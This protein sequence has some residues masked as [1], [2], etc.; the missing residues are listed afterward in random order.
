M[1]SFE[2]GPFP[3]YETARSNAFW[4]RTGIDTGLGV[5]NHTINHYKAHL[6]DCEKNPTV[7]LLIKN[8]YITG[9]P[10]NY[11]IDAKCNFNY[12]KSQPEIDTLQ[13]SVDNRIQTLYPKTKHIRQ[14]IID[15]DRVSLD[16]VKKARKYT[17]FNKLGIFL[18]RFM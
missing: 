14:Y 4:S 11:P 15:K 3:K 6:R 2:L 13:K 7:G 9:K 12:V 17:V 10:M 8:K 1:S 16:E 5:A 18:K